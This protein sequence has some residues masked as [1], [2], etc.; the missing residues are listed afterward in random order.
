MPLMLKLQRKGTKNKPFY[1]VVVQKSTEK[2]GGSIVDILGEF[3]PSKEPSLLHVNEE[4]VKH[5][6]GEGAQPTEKLRILLGKAGIMPAVDLTKLTKKKSK[7]EKPA[8]AAA[9]V[10]AAVAPTPTPETIQAPAA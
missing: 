3:D 5:W 7:Q 10:A 8:E 2:L 4:K 9:P 6:L 1:R